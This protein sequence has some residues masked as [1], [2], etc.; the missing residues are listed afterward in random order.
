MTRVED[1]DV[2]QPVDQRRAIACSPLVAS[3][4][5]KPWSS[6]R[7]RGQQQVDL[8][9]VDE[10]HLRP[11]GKVV[12]GRLAR[13]VMSACP[14]RQHGRARLVA[15]PPARGP[16]RRAAL[17]RPANAS[18][19]TR[20]LDFGT[21]SRQAQR[22]DAGRRRLQGVHD[23]ADRLHVV[24]LRAHRR[25]ARRAA[26][27]ELSKARSTRSSRWFLPVGSR[28]RRRCR[29]ASSS[30]GVELGLTL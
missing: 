14:G 10:Q 30:T 4:T 16:R 9:V 8:V 5:E 18:W 24:P 2:G 15:R 22:A 27:T 17:G 11:L 21:K 19:R 28:S 26:T 3:V 25:A 6:Q 7:D 1:D 12:G 23:V 13:R 29:A 20:G